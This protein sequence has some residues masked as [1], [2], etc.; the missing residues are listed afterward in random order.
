[1]ILKSSSWK[2]EKNH[3]SRPSLDIVTQMKE[4]GKRRLWLSS[5]L[6]FVQM[7]CYPLMTALTLSRYGREKVSLAV[8]QGVG[9]NILGIEGG[10]TAFLVTVGAVLCAAEGFSWIYSRMKTDMYLS[11]PIT[12]RRRFVI[13][14][15]NGI[16]IYF[17]PYIVSL[18]I[19][20]L[21]TAGAGAASSALFVNVLFTFVFAFIYFLAVYNVTLIAMMISGQRGMAGFFV[22]MGFLYEVILRAIL[23]NYATTYFST[24]VNRDSVEQYITPTFRLIETLGESTFSSAAGKVTP[25]GVMEY[26]VQPMMPGMGILLAEAVLFGGIAY[27]CYKRRPME[28]ISQAVAFPA[29]KGP[30]KVLLMLVS[31]L[32]GCACFCDVSG[33]DGFFAAVPGLLLGILFCQVV[34]EAVYEGDIRAFAGHKRFFAAGAAAAVLAYLFFALDICGYDTWV[35]APEQ[36]ESA[37]IEIGFGNNYRFDYVDEEDA[38]TWA[39]HYGLETMELTDVSG[40]LSLARDGMGEDARKQNPDTQLACSVKYK[41]KSGKEKYR[42]FFIDYEQE[43]TVLDILFANEEYKEGINQVLSPRMDRIFEK[44]RIYYDNG[45]QDVEIADKNGL[46]LMRAYQEDLRKM[47]FTDVKEAVPCGILRLRYKTEKSQEYTLE[48]PVFP[49]YAGTIEYLRGKNVE[50]YL[51]ISPKAVGKLNVIHYRE[52]G[53]TE[54]IEQ[55]GFFGTAVSMMQ[56]AD[57]VEKEYD[58]RDQ[59]EELLGYLYPGT[60]V[61]WCYTMNTFDHDIFVRAEA[62]DDPEAYLYHWGDTDFMVRKGELPEFVKED[63]GISDETDE[64]ESGRE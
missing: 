18:C 57:A 12:A 26:L 48:Y 27:Y 24:Y 37:A 52:E 33:Y 39:E 41:M 11:Q 63:I 20:L 23:E 59:I 14:Y 64:Q 50:L 45:M 42:S 10:P 8:W 31:G 58:K 38:V 30:V 34:V 51:S 56:T 35:P 4:N 5:L 49:S 17:V 61:S 44:S 28:A 40:V 55:G 1:M 21:V 13:V 6:A 3:N 36:V 62:S 60:L 29:V 47:S 53:D 22:L 9:H 19:A 7:L 32:L 43:K 2:A 54:V 16:L 25:S 15:I 46:A